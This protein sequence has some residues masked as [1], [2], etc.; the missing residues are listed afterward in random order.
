MRFDKFSFFFPQST[1]QKWDIQFLIFI[2]S[3]EKYILRKHLKTTVVINPNHQKSTWKNR[4]EIKE[5]LYCLVAHLLKPHLI[6]F[7]FTDLRL[8]LN[9]QCLGRPRFERKPGRNFGETQFLRV[10]W[11]ATKLDFRD[12]SWYPLSLIWNYNWWPR[13]TIGI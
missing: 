6:G 3:W 8:G 12:P 4:F 11:L 2:I 5:F 1:L 10:A 9:R 7:C 13:K